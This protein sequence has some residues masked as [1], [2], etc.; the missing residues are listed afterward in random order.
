[1]KRLIEKKSMKFGW[2][3]LFSFLCFL[4]L[5]SCEESTGPEIGVS[6]S[7]YK[8]LISPENSTISSNGG[9]TKILVKVYSGDDTTNV[10][11]GVSVNFSATQAGIDI[12]LHIDN[13]L[14]DSNGYARAT[15]Y[16]GSKTGSIAV[17]ASIQVSAT[18]VVLTAW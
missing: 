8:L 14:T 13:S 18:P 3:I 12:I 15:V 1:M 7:T 17:T 5:F 9:S 10:R 11:S 2:L 4:V 6:K 16:A